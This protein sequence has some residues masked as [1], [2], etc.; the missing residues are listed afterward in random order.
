MNE[1][2]TKVLLPE[3][4][5][6]PRCLLNMDTSNVEPIP[7][8]RVLDKFDEYLDKRDYEGAKK[9]LEY[10]RMEAKAGR[11][12][13]GELSVTNELMGVYRK[14]GL[15]NE[16]MESVRSA[17]EL[18]SLLDNKETISAGTSYLNAG[19]VC[20]R[21]G[22]PEKALE[23]FEKA[24][25]VYEKNLKGTDAR[26]GGLYN[27][28]ALA[29][30][31]LKEYQEAER[32]YKMA[33]EVMRKQ[34]EGKLEMAITY[35]NMANAIEA[36]IG[37]DAAEEK[38]IHYLDTAEQLLNDKNLE[39]NGYYAFVCEKCA[40]TFEYYGW[41]AAAQDLKKR[42]EEIYGRNKAC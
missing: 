32:Y 38:I 37:L 15:E 3:D 26:M 17:M 24:K 31:D 6:E 41:F 28:M 42:A 25:A 7:V 11:D 27:N 21:F 19:T 23:Y 13:R 9:H 4:Y 8:M 36:D 10:W 33:L 40:P 12:L 5:E 20:D 30:A 1:K 2:D 14:M 35:L 34:P 22:R 29:L 16:A 39:R 18:I